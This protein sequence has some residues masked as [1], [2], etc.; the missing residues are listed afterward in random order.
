MGFQ[1]E[2]S[3]GPATS[4]AQGV[5]LKFL[6]ALVK[7][8]RIREDESSAEVCERVI[9][10]ETLQQRCCWIDAMCKGFDEASGIPYVGTQTVFVSHAWSA[11]F[12][13]LQLTLTAYE[14]KH[15]PNHYYY[16]DLFALNQRLDT[17]ISTVN[18]VL[19]AIDEWDRPLP[20]GRI[21]CL[22]E[23]WQGIELGCHVQMGFSRE[24][25]VRFA[26]A[27][28]SLEAQ[29]ERVAEQV[30]VSCASSTVPSDLQLILSYIDAS[31]V[32]GRDAFNQKLR[33][34]LMAYLV[35]SALGIEICEEAATARSKIRGHRR[36]NAYLP[37]P[38]RDTFCVESF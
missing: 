25:A 4:P 26:K 21:W 20:L 11:R 6:R 29:I 24:A 35:D 7:E 15:G 38:L 1:S 37:V 13:A 18:T 12:W 36:F 32:G 16:I 17:A 3:Q 33:S 2:S 30:D 5:N 14:A 34:K 31:T 27:V 9:R 28:D 23:M 8:Y 22:F 10:A 19:V